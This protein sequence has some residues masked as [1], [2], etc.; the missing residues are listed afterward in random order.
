MI[1]HVPVTPAPPTGGGLGWVS[2]PPT[3]TPPA[4]DEI[5]R[6]WIPLGRASAATSAALVHV[7]G[8]RSGHLINASPPSYPPACETS[9]A[10]PRARTGLCEKRLANID[11]SL[12]TEGDQKE[13]KRRWGLSKKKGEGGGGSNRCTV[14]SWMIYAILSSPYSLEK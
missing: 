9:A 8:N 5:R 11:S 2:P 3:P 6:T 14:L 10:S 13:K 1:C 12:C 4:V 7:Q